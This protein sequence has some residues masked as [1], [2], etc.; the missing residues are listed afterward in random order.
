MVGAE[1]KQ[2]T[3][4]QNPVATAPLCVMELLTQCARQ[5]PAAAA[6]SSPEKINGAASGMAMPMTYAQLASQ[7]RSLASRL[8]EWELGRGDRIATILPAGPGAA[9]MMLAINCCATYAP[10]NPRAHPEEVQR[11]LK[12]IKADAVVIEKDSPWRATLDSMG[13]AIIEMSSPADAPAGTIEF[14]LI[15]KP[16]SPR[17]P[18]RT[19]M[20]GDEDILAVLQTSGTTARPKIVP[21]MQRAMLEGI[22]HNVDLLELSPQDR[23]L[24]VLPPINPMGITTIIYSLMAGCEISIAPGFSSTEFFKWAR[25]AR[26]TWFTVPPAIHQAILRHSKDHADWAAKHSPRLVRSGAATVPGPLFREIENLWHAPLVEVY[27]MSECP[28]ISSNHFK[29]E[30]RKAGSVGFPTGIEMAMLDEGGKIIPRGAGISGEILIRGRIVTAG[31][32]DNP[33]E[34]SAAW[35]DGY[36]RTGDLGRFDD[37]GFLFVIGRSKEMINRGGVKIAPR[38]IE[39]VIRSFPAVSEAIAFAIPDAQLGENIAVAAVLKEGQSMTE[40]ELRQKSAE[41]LSS[42]KVPSR[43][44]FMNEIPLSPAGKPQ[45]IGMAE[46][47]GLKISEPTAPAH[48]SYQGP[49]NS[50]EQVLAAIWERVLGLGRLVGI[51]ESFMEMGGDSLQAVAMF[52]EVQ[53][54]LGRELP[55]ATLLAAETI[56]KLADAM[57]RQGWKLP[58][59]LVIPIQP[60]G[61]NAPLFCISGMHG[62]VFIFYPLAQ[63]L[64]KNQPVYGLQLPEAGSPIYTRN[65]KQLAVRLLEEMRRVQ[66]TGP[67]CLA[68]FSFGGYVA[69]EMA[70]LLWKQG[71]SVELLGILDTRGPGYPQKRKLPG[72]I[73]WHV[74]AFVRS[75]D[76]TQHLLN[77][78]NATRDRFSKPLEPQVAPTNV[79]P[80]VWEIE[81]ESISEIESYPIEPY[82][83]RMVLFRATEKPKWMEACAPDATMGWRKIA[84]EVEVVNVPGSHWTILSVENT[85][86]LAKELGKRIDGKSMQPAARDMKI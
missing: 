3:S 78:L 63:Q 38:E 57:S 81:R 39:E 19:G 21:T 23:C 53:R 4:A 47:L 42:Y 11:T 18:C 59:S 28:M 17:R 9:A 34:N 71:Q 48:L 36:F 76:K 66:P 40:L 13:I 20:A 32:E 6:I 31:Y 7:S 12:L 60:K 49:R 30:W 22:R 82:G 62:H 41:R 73:G 5:W 55:V 83:G 84:K 74:K 79:D 24:H 8:N 68:G 61:N 45:R 70:Q 75:R 46:K 54:V 29:S 15:Q 10:I 77:R 85:E 50:L 65:I 35:V 16:N 27:A 25:E 52:A 2:F 1:R 56:E 44:L 86:R 37:D 80:R 64:G 67:Y 58:D 43:I 72:R 51:D 26:P 14:F 33:A 69:Y